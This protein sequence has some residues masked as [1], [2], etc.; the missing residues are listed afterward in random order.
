MSLVGT[1]FAVLPGKPCPWLCYSAITRLS[2]YC[3]LNLLIIFGSS[4]SVDTLKVGVLK[5]Y[6]ILVPVTVHRRSS[7]FDRIL[8]RLAGNYE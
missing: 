2:A 3:F 6:F 5:V 1:G 4:S 8:E 7:C